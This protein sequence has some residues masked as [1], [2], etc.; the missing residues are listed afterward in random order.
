[1]DYT[2]SGDPQ[3]TVELLWG[4]PPAPRRG[5]KPKL[6]VDDIA[7]TALA[8]ADGEGLS[9]VTLR[10]IADELGVTAMSLY[11]YVPG[12]SELLD[13][14]ADRAW[15]DYPMPRH[16]RLGWRARVE[17]VARANWTVYQAHPWLLQIATSRP[18]LG[19]HHTAKY[20]YE[21]SAVDSL[22]L[23][24]IDM[25]LIVGFVNDYVRGA[26]RL[27]ADTAA[28]RTE[29]GITDQQWWQQAA[30]ALARVLDP[31]RFPTA[32]RVGAAAGA[33]YDAAHNPARAFDFGL[34]RLLDGL[35][36]YIDRFR[37]PASAG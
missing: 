9:A 17:S 12:K 25:D 4:V 6:T 8:I 27:A 37:P 16:G 20:D 19:P 31:A 3:R 34:H 14:L 23:T 36:T 30:P 35:Q 32:V 24:D 7:T 28:A 15:R 1:M 33:E 11:G 26:A 22:G 18:L 5:P 2:G 21:L 10:R 13:L 29:T